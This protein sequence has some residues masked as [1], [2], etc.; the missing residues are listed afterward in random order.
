MPLAEI[1]RWAVAAL[2]TAVL[3]WAAVSDIRVRK[4][5]NGSVL[6]LLALFAPWALLNT[7]PWVLWALAGGFI[8]LAVSVG[9]YAAGIVGAGDSKMFA[10]VAL[11][12][13]LTEL[14]RLALVTALAGGVIAAISVASRPN[15]ALV[16]LTLRGKGDFGRGIPYGVAI[17]I[18]GATLIWA[19]LLGVPLTWDMG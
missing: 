2:F 9:L 16:M 11:F 18:A 17:A 3:A 5:P 6:A 15:R 7:G 19:R 8:A 1:A 12:A 14:P 10:A 4:I 13:G